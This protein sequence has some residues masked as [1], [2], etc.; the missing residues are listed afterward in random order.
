MQDRQSHSPRRSAERTVIMGQAADDILDGIVCCVCGVYHDKFLNEDD[1]QGYGVP[2]P[3][4]DCAGQ[5]K[6]E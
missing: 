1:F 3:C 6:G 4:K 2:T 5:R